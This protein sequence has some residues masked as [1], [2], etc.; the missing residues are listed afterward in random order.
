MSA[1]EIA[2]LVTAAALLL[3]ALT[4]YRKF[5]PER[6]DIT[7]TSADKVNAMTL[8]FAGDVNR[9][10]E[11]LREDLD[12]LKAAFDQYR[13]DT[14]AR[15]SEMAVELR[16]ERAEKLAVKQ[17]NEQLRGRV[18]ALET[19]VATLKANGENPND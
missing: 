3:A 11:S 14:E 8:R 12:E 1:A 5:K 18:L 17:E 16:A 2:A 9:D 15:L 13:K 19:E 10:N 4:A 6:N 7:I